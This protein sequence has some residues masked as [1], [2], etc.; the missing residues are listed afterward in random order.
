MEM[1]PSRL[2]TS[3]R[4]IDIIVIVK[5]LSLDAK[6]TLGEVFAAGCEKPTH[7]ALSGTAYSTPN[8]YSIL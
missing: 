5:A 3:T 6:V 2:T 4:E 1:K 8:G 7:F